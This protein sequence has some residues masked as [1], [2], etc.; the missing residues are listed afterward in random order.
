MY[1][2]MPLI[3]ATAL[4]LLTAHAQDAG[5]LS[6]VWRA[7]FL[8]P[9][10][11]HREATFTI[12]GDSGLWTDARFGVQGVGNRCLGHEF[13]VI[14]KSHSA[15]EIEFIVNASSVLTGCDNIGATVK[16]TVD[17]DLEGHFRDGRP[18]RLVRE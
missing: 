4:L 2:S 5:P 9:N 1:K 15:T 13:P 7:H 14:F 6:G 8:A 10:G 17:G 18:I 12:N 16:A 3:L 11:A